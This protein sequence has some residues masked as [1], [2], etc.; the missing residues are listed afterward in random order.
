[1]PPAAKKKDGDSKKGSEKEKEGKK[2]KDKE[3]KE[4]LRDAKVKFMGGLDTTDKEQRAVFETVAT[5]VLKEFPG[6][7]PVLL[8]ALNAAEKRASGAHG[9]VVSGRCF[10]GDA[11]GQ[12]GNEKMTTYQR[13]QGEEWMNEASPGDTQ[14]IGQVSVAG[15]QT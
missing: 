13:D 5:E 2:S 12:T 10:L 4:A 7:I 14:C 6:H 1:M 15:G 9:A 8:E 3:L 11:H